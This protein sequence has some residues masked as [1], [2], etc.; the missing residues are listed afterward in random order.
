MWLL[1]GSAPTVSVDNTTGCQLYLN[2]D[3]LETAITTAKSSEINVMVPGTSPDG[4]WVWLSS[5]CN[6]ESLLIPCILRT[7][8]CFYSLVTLGD[9]KTQKS[10]NQATRV[11][12]S[13][14]TLFTEG[15]ILIVV[16]SQYC[17]LN[18]HCRNNTTMCSPKGS[19]RRHRS[20]TQVPK[21][22]GIS[23]Q[24]GFCLNIRSCFNLFSS[25]SVC[26]WFCL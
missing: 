10:L 24:S 25:E 18:M 13:E 5:L 22:R 3:S 2:Q 17:R 4:D 8:K 7:T 11:Y 26:L 21:L 23:V 19:S 15:I 6:N 20:R 1:Q 12:A 9:T 16:L 14:R